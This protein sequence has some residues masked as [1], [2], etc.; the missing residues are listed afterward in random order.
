[1]SV[2]PKT[3]LAGYAK[4]VG[5]HVQRICREHRETLYLLRQ[6]LDNIDRRCWHAIRKQLR[7]EPE[8]VGTRRGNVATFFYEDVQQ[9]CRQHRSAHAFL[10]EELDQTSRIAG[11]LT[12][13]SA[14]LDAKSVARHRQAQMQLIKVLE[15][16][17]SRLR[18][19]LAE[20]HLRIAKHIAQTNKTEL[21]DAGGGLP[22]QLIESGRVIAFTA[23][24]GVPHEA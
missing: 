9:M 15:D 17:G 1:M 4:L 13:T 5:E 8:V 6:E 22:R 16:R 18:A 11:L 14:K 21:A 3:D 19:D 20:V 23:R 24:K 10:R 7:E 2:D 12:D